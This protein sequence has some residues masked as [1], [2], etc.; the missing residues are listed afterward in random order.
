[1]NFNILRYEEIDSTNSEAARQARLGASEGLCVIARSQTDGRGRNGRHWV[2]NVDSGLYFSVV[3]RPHI[4]LR[5]LPLITLM[6]GV[7]AHDALAEL[8]LEADIKWVNDILIGDK[9]I[10]GILSE[11]IETPTGLAVIVG[12]GI[13]LTSNDLPGEIEAISTS[14]KAETGK[15]VNRE[16]LAE[17]VTRYLSYFYGI[18]TGENGPAQIVEHWRCRSS[19]F[20]GKHVRVDLENGVVEGLTDGLEEN[21]ALRVIS[22]N[23]SVTIVHAGDVTR[24]RAQ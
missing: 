6:T 13:N 24:L 8:E 7:A 23:A 2:S 17:L 10:C 5:F 1:M 18:L 9:K 11:S 3:L 20:M 14:V 12:I 21:G 4:Q 19:Y 15:T 16:E 22:D